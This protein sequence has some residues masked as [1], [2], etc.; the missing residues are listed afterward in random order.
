M[1]E[2]EGGG[3]GGNERDERRERGIVRRT[4]RYTALHLKPKRENDPTNLKTTQP[5]ALLVPV[6]P[7]A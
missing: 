4:D 6:N 7:R 1:S 2:G 3:K 5:L